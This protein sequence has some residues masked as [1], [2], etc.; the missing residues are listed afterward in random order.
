MAAVPLFWDTNMAAV[1]SCEDAVLVLN[2]GLVNR[3]AHFCLRYY[4]N[5]ISFFLGLTLNSLNV[6][7]QI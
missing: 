2:P 4:C 7:G 5:S 1:T 3:V 6:F